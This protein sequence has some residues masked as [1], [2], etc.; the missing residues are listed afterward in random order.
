MSIHEHVDSFAG[1]P[2]KDYDP[3]VGIVTRTM[4]RQEFQLVEGSSRK[5]WAIERHGLRHTVQFGR[6]GSAGQTQTKEFATEEEAQKSYEKLIAEKVKKGYVAVKQPATAIEPAAAPGEIPEIYRLRLAYDALDSGAS[7]TQLLATFLQDPASRYVSGLIFGAWTYGGE[8]SSALVEALVAAREKLP[9]LK[10]LFL[11]DIVMEE[12]EISW[13]QQSDMAPLFE[14]YPQLEHFR[15]RGG[16][17]LRLGTLEHVQL[18]TLVLESGGLSAAVVRE[19]A[20]AK[21]P[22]LEHL[23]LWLGTPDYGG[24]AT[25]EDLKPILSGK[26]FPKLRYLGLRD[27]EIADQVAMAVAKAPL[28]QRIRVLDLSLGNLSDEG[29]E[30]LVAS[31]AVARLDKLD[32]HHH[33]V[34]EPVVQ[35]LKELGISVDASERQKPADWDPEH[36]YIAVSE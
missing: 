36:R 8:D 31:P 10:A 14:A 29:A 21:L 6:I 20:K 18:Q 11:G 25:V 3:S 1:K 23:E 7:I 13:I 26:R 9:N 33:F 24:D 28:L 19:V 27:C 4:S 16:T 22:A 5:F 12:Q 35:K 17:D 34:S 30:A 2:V 32:I 15:V